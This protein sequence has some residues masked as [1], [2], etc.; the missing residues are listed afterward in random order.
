[1]TTDFDSDLDLAMHHAERAAGGG[2]AGILDRL[3][4]HLGRRATVQ[5]VF[6]EPIDREDITII[7][8]AKIRYGVGGGGGGESKSGDD[9]GSSGTGGGAGAGV[10]AGPVGYIEISKGRASFHSTEGPQVMW[11]LILVCGITTWLILRG[12]RKLVR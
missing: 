6:G 12:L 10:T 2:M 1:M 7:P 4:D 3:A 8:V 9:G 5:A 11:P